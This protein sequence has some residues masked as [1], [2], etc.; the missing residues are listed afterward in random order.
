MQIVTVASLQFAVWLNAR[1]DMVQICS[2]FHAEKNMISALRSDNS[3]RQ[4]QSTTM[5]KVRQHFENI[6]STEIESLAVCNCVHCSLEITLQSGAALTI[7][8]TTSYVNMFKCVIPTSWNSPSSQSP[9]NPAPRTRGAPA[10]WY[11][12]QA[13]L[14]GTVSLS[15]LHCLH[16]VVLEKEAEV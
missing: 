2:R 10:L 9:R 15:I 5:N 12:P 8:R 16:S 4:M 1:I 11:L 14:P 7:R 13:C 3:R 6:K